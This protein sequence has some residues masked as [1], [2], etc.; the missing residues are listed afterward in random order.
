MICYIVSKT[1][2]LMNDFVTLWLSFDPSPCKETTSRQYAE[3]DGVVFCFTLLLSCPRACDLM[4]IQPL[5][6][7]DV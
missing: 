5:E 1:Q 2:R 4:P 6:Q 3:L 7:F